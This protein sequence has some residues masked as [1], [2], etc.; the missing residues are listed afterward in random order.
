MNRLKG[1][2][3]RSRS[4]SRSWLA[5]TVG[6]LSLLIAGACLWCALPGSGRV[7]A[8]TT[9]SEVR[10]YETK[11][12]SRIVPFDW[13][14]AGNPEGERDLQFGEVIHPKQWRLLKLVA[15]KK[16]GGEADVDMARPLTWLYSQKQAGVTVPD[17]AIAEDEDDD[18]SLIAVD[19]AQLAAFDPRQLV[20]RTIYISVPEC[21][22]DG[23]AKV[24]AVEDCPNLKPRPGLEYQLVTATFKHRGAK[25]VDVHVAGLSAPIGSTPNHPFWSEDKQ[26]FVRADT[27][28]PGEHLRQADGSL[29]TVTA[30]IP[31]PGTHNV[32][33]LEVHLDHVYHVANNGVLVHNGSA[34]W[35]YQNRVAETFG[36][37]TGRASTEFVGQLKPKR[38]AD[39]VS[40]DITHAMEAKHIHNWSRS[41]YNPANIHTTVGAQRQFGMVS[42]MKDLSNGFPKVTYYTNHSGMANHLRDLAS[43]ANLR[44]V[45][46]EFHP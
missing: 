35:C 3:Y 27:L 10:Q 24:L 6:L 28:Q 39:G 1:Q 12:I 37:T 33:N 8:V 7:D 16:G 4:R 40:S 5:S 13:V 26:Q 31:R 20:G 30:V 9:P 17:E 44:N 43:R 14:L 18:D 46:V 22:I 15:P 34:W 21:G 2:H 41:P 45:S 38:F 42:Q 32:Y 19:E 23:H 29:T 11:R 36:F 25:V